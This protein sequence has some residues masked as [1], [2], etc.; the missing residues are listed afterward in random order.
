MRKNELRKLR[1]LNVTDQMM[2]K[3]SRIVEVRCQKYDYDQHRY[4]EYKAEKAEYRLLLRCQSLGAYL[5]ASV[6]FADDLRDGV[7][8]P[9]YE[10]FINPAGEE[11]IT[12]ELDREGKETRW[13]TGMIQNLE[14]V[15]DHDSQITVED[16][17]KVG[18]T[19]ISQDGKNNIKDLLRESGIATNRTDAV[20]MIDI[21]QQTM[22]E[23]RIEEKEKREQEPWDADMK[24][25]P[26]IPYGFKAWMEV[27]TV[28]DDY[29]IYNYEKGGAKKGYCRH[30]GK[31]VPITKIPHHREDYKCPVC[32]RAAEL[33]CVGKIKTVS[34]GKCYYGTL[35][36]GIQG[37]FAVRDFEI[38]CKIETEDHRRPEYHMHE[39]QRM[40]VRDGRIDTYRYEMYKNKYTRWCKADDWRP[41]LC[42]GKKEVYRKNIAHVEKKMDRNSSLSCMIKAGL[43]M[44]AAKYLHME[45]MYPAIE[46]LAKAGME[47]MA[48]EYAERPYDFEGSINE[49]ETELFKMLGI[50][51][52]RL[53]RMRAIGPGK[54]ALAWMQAEKRSNTEWDDMMI[55]VFAEA[56]IE[57]VSLKFISN[58]M[59]YKRIWN[60][61]EKQ[62]GASGESIQQ[63]MQTWKDYLDMARKLRMDLE[64]E[65][66]YRPKDLWTAHAD[67]IDQ[68]EAKGI[69]KIA[70]E[71]KKQ[72]PEVDIVCGTLG[73]YE[74]EDGEYCIKAPT[75]I[76]DIV[77]EGTILRHCIHTCD[78]YFERITSRESYL[79]FLRRKN[80]E[81]KP[82]YTIEVEPGGNIRQKRTVGDT[83]NQDLNAA[84]PFLKKWQK[85]IKRQLSEEEKA[86]AEEAD[87]KR[88]ENYKELRKNGNKIWHGRLQGKLLADVL[89]QDF[90]EAI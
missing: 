75:G 51:R 20:E 29:I 55:K 33:I 15:W 24:L 18:K 27:E 35:I 79:V 71:I 74:F 81:K 19:F 89:E 67:A 58:R 69:E 23:R 84:V 31:D 64:N 6:F 52:G 63:T 28:R 54:A 88:K 45:R 22:R 59:T 5:K 43:R 39:Y 47:T 16:R 83:Q 87:R 9:K 73:K 17:H 42:E 3:A 53:N 56:G 38:S 7:R 66:I 36:Q 60:Y 68:I 2:E 25:M 70:K 41:W 8:T 90:M 80:A 21:W 40:L 11:Y 76:S 44:S 32:G 13:R 46:K 50:D 10:V 72:F 30:C 14:G 77:R 4:I 62:A 49:G 12:R 78:Y 26:K 85:K 86:L 34:S 82:W 1:A 65:M 48:L 61:M 57:P 37:G